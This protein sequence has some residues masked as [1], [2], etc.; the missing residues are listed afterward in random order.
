MFLENKG[1]AIGNALLNQF[2]DTREVLHTKMLSFSYFNAVTLA[3]VLIWNWSDRPVKTRDYWDAVLERI[4]GTVR[5]LSERGLP[6]HGSNEIIG[7]P[8]NGNYLG[9][10]ELIAVFD[11]FLAQDI[12]RNANKGRGHTSYLSKTIC[13]EFIQLMATRVREAH[14]YQSE[15]CQVF[16]GFCGLDPRYFSC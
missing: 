4:T 8:K 2:H 9:T 16:L 6:F 12:D 1:T 11:Q 13:K 14:L 15:D 5:Y 10:L 7:S 3:V